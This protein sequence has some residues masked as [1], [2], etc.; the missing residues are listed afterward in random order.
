MCPDCGEEYDKNGKCSCNR[1]SAG[2]KMAKKGK[3][4]KPNP[5]QKKGY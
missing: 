5:F 2:K 1:S 3:G 4:K